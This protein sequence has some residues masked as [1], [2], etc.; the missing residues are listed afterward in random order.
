MKNE[1]VKNDKTDL[2]ESVPYYK[3]TTLF[4]DDFNKEAEKNYKNYIAKLRK[5]PAF[6]NYVKSHIPKTDY[7]AMLSKSQKESIKSG[8]LKLMK[9]K[10]GKLY[11]ELVNPKTNRIAKKINLAEV[12]KTPA[13][14]QAQSMYMLS[15]QMAEL[16][17]QMQEIQTSIEA[18][19]VGQEND[20]L[21]GAYSCQQKFLQ[22]MKVDNPQLKKDMLLKIAM[23]AEDARNKLML[24]QK[25]KIKAIKEIPESSI[26][27]LMSNNS[28]NSQTVS[29]V[30]DGLYANNLLSIVEMMCYRELGENEASRLSLKYYGGFLDDAYFSEPNL[31]DRLDSLDSSITGSTKQIHY[32]KEILPEMKENIITLP[33]KEVKKIGGKKNGKKV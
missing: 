6:I 19:R 32:W 10:N 27:K 23:D 7:V 18:V 16:A 33:E 24:S 20:R 22:A 25:E 17:I 4:S 30:R 5:A 21:A 3:T 13:L 14:E 28:K 31:I 2:E 29:E 8:A 15:S 1:L 12:K 9:G 26:G 11:A